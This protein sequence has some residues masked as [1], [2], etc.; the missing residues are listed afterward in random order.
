MVISVPSRKGIHRIGRERSGGRRWKGKIVT[1]YQRKWTNLPTYQEVIFIPR[2][3]LQLKCFR[4]FIS[5]TYRLTSSWKN[6]K[7]LDNDLNLAPSH[8]PNRTLQPP[9]VISRI[10]APDCMSWS[11]AGLS[12]GIS[13]P[14]KC[15]FLTSQA[16]EKSKSLLPSLVCYTSGVCACL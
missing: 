9:A 8:H 7:L 1:V 3:S 4:C 12:F 6:C 5:K 2:V 14:S 11:I 13:L 16:S 15:H 10:L